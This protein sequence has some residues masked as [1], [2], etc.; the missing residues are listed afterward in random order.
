[1]PTD[2]ENYRIGH[3]GLKEASGFATR[4]LHDTNCV[5]APEMSSP[6]RGDAPMSMTPHDAGPRGV[7]H[8]PVD[9]RLP[10][11]DMP[12]GLLPARGCLNPD[13]HPYG[14]DPKAPNTYGNVVEKRR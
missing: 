10:R 9:S 7:V 12:P 5:S 3:H 6:L 1:M 8:V 14:G 13:P 11:N 4:S 2:N